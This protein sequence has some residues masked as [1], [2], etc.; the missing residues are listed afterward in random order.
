MC[1][2]VW[3]SQPLHF[4]SVAPEPAS[5]GRSAEYNYTFHSDDGVELA[6][7]ARLKRALRVD[8]M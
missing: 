6:I 2:S 7:T 8:Q 4:D 3:E 5:I 1:E